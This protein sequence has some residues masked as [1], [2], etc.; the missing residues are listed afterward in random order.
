MTTNLLHPS[1]VGP[2]DKR[3]PE[4][5]QHSAGILHPQPTV[6][7]EAGHVLGAAD[8]WPDTAGERGLVRF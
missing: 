4:P 2:I 3:Q 5:L 8:V 6:V 7:D 1:Y